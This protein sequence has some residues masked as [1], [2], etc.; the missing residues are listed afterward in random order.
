MIIVF[1]VTFIISCLVHL[2]LFDL[3]LYQ[4]LGAGFILSSII[5]LIVPITFFIFPLYRS[6]QGGK[7]IDTKLVYT[8]GYMAILSAGNIPVERIFERVT[9]VE[10]CGAIKNLAKR[11]I[12]NLKMLGLDV[13]SSLDEISARSPSEYFSKFLMGIVNT[14]ETSGDLKNYL[15]FETQQLLHAKKEQFRKTF[16]TLTIL[17]EIYITVIIM[18]PILFI[19]M[20]T[21]LSILGNVIY[22]LSPTEQLNLLVFFGLPVMSMFFIVILNSV[23]P[24]EE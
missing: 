22:G 4:Y 20:L 7:E 19:V 5:T 23:I 14:A 6:S 8:A 1:A 12:T 24:K 21:L 13:T 17:A 2:F 11:F 3:S 15:I 18:A 16:G 9:E 10:S